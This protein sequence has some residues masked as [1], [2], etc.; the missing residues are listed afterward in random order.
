MFSF[1][2]AGHLLFRTASPVNSLGA[3]AL[4]LLVWS[5]KDLFDPSL[6]LTFLS[7]LAIVGVA[8]PILQNFAEIGSWRP[9][10]RTPYP[11]QCARS[12]RTFC[13]ALYWSEDEWRREQTKLSHS[14]HLFKTP[15]AH[16]L[17]RHHFQRPL[18]YLWAAVVVSA[19][20]QLLL[21]PLQIVYFHRLSLSSLILNVVV[22]ILLAILAAIALVALLIAQM[23]ESVA[24]PLFVLANGVDWLMLHSVDPFAR[25]GIASI[26]IPEYSGTPRLIYILY[27]VPLV[28]FAVALSRWRPVNGGRGRRQGQGTTSGRSRKQEQGRTWLGTLIRSLIPTTCSCLLLLPLMFALLVWHPF[29]SKL[30]GGKLRIDFLDVGQGDSALLTMPDGA[31]LLVDGGGKPQFLKNSSGG[32]G[33]S[34][35]EMVVCEYIWRQGIDS[36]D[37]VL[38]THADADHIDGL[39]DVVKNFKV[40]SAL[41]GRTP[42]ND[43]AFL[44][45]VQTL[46]ARGTPVQIVQAGDVLKFGNV[47]IDVLWPPFTGTNAP[48][49]NNDS[50]VL[51]VRFGE[52]TILLTGDIEKATEELLR[53]TVRQADVVKVPHH[54]SRT[55]STEPFVSVVR[56]R[57]AVISVGQTSMFGHPH[58]EVVDRWKGIGAQVLTTGRSGMITVTTD[59]RDLVV[60][61][62]VKEINGN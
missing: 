24:A 2:A 5:P 14:Y 16:W 53:T 28:L 4:V 47:E 19:S 50:V 56:P 26:R 21:L 52:R 37:Y 59:G 55:S 15:I 41:V 11:P 7:V 1:V 34:I 51:S 10:R 36:V 22:G 32:R 27:Y 58:P 46:D 17:E 61:R 57:V 6:Q 60:E 48:S 33:R 44:E 45:F 38:A 13:E 31:T 40:R 43:A 18:R 9:S 20:V 30:A 25:F 39:K 23:S 8:W 54:G 29:S 12:V 3:A 49:R 35:G 62:F 42:S